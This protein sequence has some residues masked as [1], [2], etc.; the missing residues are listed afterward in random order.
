M[1]VK[2]SPSVVVVKLF[3]ARG[4]WLKQGSGFFVRDG[5]TIVTNYHVVEWATSAKV[6]LHDGTSR[7]VVGIEMCDEL[8]DVAV[9]KVARGE[10]ER[11]IQPLQLEPNELP[12]IGSN[13]YVIGSPLGLD[14][15]ITMGIVSNNNREWRGSQ[16]IQFDASISPGSSG[17]AMLNDKGIAIGIARGST[18]GFGNQNLNFA[19]PASAIAALLNENPKFQS[20]SDLVV[21]SKRKT[22]DPVRAFLD[23]GTAKARDTAAEILDRLSTS[24][25]QFSEYWVLRGDIYQKRR[26]FVAAIDAFN[27]AVGI[28]AQDSAI[29]YRIGLNY[30]LLQLNEEALKAYRQGKDVN[31]KD[32][33]C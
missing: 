33:N 25:H 17:S 14:N 7:S 15:T 28:D 6:A 1:F 19:A 5:S 27:R 32:E 23:K 13:V 11:E 21:E 24:S 29:W 26:Q 18:E 31:P 8:T 20:L 12:A 30:E 4:K 2:A 10:M 16:C 3:D 9:L 22:F